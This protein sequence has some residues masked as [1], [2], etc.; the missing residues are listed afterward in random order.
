MG[1][2]ENNH[3]TKECSF[4]I[5]KIAMNEIEFYEKV[6][7]WRCYFRGIREGLCEIEVRFG[8]AFSAKRLEKAF[9]PKHNALIMG[10]WAW[11]VLGKH[12]WPEL[13]AGWGRWVVW[14]GRWHFSLCRPGKRCEW[15]SKYDEVIYVYVRA[16]GKDLICVFQD[17]CMEERLWDGKREARTFLESISFHLNPKEDNAKECSNYHTISLISHTSK[18]MLK[19]LQA[20][21]QQYVNRI[22]RCSSW[23]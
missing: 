7:C 21:L 9:P 3:K 10:Q 15:Y 2:T 5:W 22:P 11:H 6:Y 20:R 18:L 23:F 8:E 16:C 14:H 17:L 4:E 1:E 12:L 19:I 13:R